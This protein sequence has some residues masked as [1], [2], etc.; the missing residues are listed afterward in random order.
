MHTTPEHYEGLTST[1]EI[2][3]LGLNGLEVGSEH[4]EVSISASLHDSLTIRLFTVSMR[5]Q[6]LHHTQT[7]S[8]TTML[9]E[10]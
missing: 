1:D 7:F 3:W 4:V 9:S 5:Q 6:R 2:K 8:T 10:I